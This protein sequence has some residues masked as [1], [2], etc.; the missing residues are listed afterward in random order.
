MKVEEKP[1]SGAPLI[2]IG[3][4]LVAAII[5]GL[6]FY[7]S[8][9]STAGNKTPVP[10]NS[11]RTQTA[12]TNAPP[13]AQPPNLLGSPTAAVTVE[14]FAD[15][16]CPSCAAT[17]P[18]LKQIQS[19]Y[20]SR[21]RF[22]FRNYPLSMHDKS[23]EAAVAAEA[24]GMQG[25]FW[26]MNNQLFTNQRSWASDPN[27][28][29]VWADYAQKIGI[30]VER[31]KTDMA[32]MQ[33]KS[34]VDLDLQRGKALN[35][36]TTPTVFVNGIAVPYQEVSVDGLRNIIDAALQAAPAPATQPQA[37]PAANS[38]VPANASPNSAKA[39]SNTN[40]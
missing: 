7:S 35:I 21:I 38:T 19:L 17:H 10:A 30:D 27:Y 36:N 6:W 15:F 2:I 37:K 26:D 39:A 5:G 32:G 14:E 23:Y 1:K 9:K 31:W 18:T 16:Q 29:D 3:I 20:G 28:K 11:P 33:A 4:V 25:K 40:K 12:A 22:I 13:G 8:S 34:R 24:A